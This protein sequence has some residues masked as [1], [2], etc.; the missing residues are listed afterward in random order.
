MS[1]T[2]KIN[3]I[4]KMISDFWECNSN[5]QIEK[6]AFAIV[7]AIYTAV[8]FEGSTEAGNKRTDEI[9]KVETNFYDKEE[10]FPDCTVQVLT[11]TATGEVS[12]GWWKN[13]KE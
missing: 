2:E 9:V 3:L 8:G 13:G 6:S 5:E 10:I 7:T 1:D 12:V 11:N 4:Q